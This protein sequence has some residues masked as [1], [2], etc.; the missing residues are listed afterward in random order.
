MA[1]LEIAL[2]AQGEFLYS[3]SKYWVYLITLT[4]KGKID[5]VDK[6]EI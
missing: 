4:S 6:L 5:L 1:R 2:V 3:A